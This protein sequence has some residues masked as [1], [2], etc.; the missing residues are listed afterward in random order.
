MGCE[1]EKLVSSLL[2][3]CTNNWR[4]PSQESHTIISRSWFG[5]HSEAGASNDDM[6]SII[7]WFPLLL[8][9]QDGW[10]KLDRMVGLAFINR[11]GNK[12]GRLYSEGTWNFNHFWEYLR[13]YFRWCF[14][15]KIYIDGIASKSSVEKCCS[16]LVTFSVL[17]ISIIL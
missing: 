4:S 9:G 6:G 7:M 10:G 8:S 16:V 1:H 2:N 15:K 5:R 13:W 17:L 3:V 12:F 14:C 11:I